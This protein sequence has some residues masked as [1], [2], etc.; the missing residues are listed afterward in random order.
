MSDLASRVR[1]FFPPS[2]SFAYVS[3]VTQKQYDTAKSMILDLL[4]IGVP[5]DHLLHCG[6]SRELIYFTFT[7]L[8]LR[9]PVGFDTAGIPQYSPEFLESLFESHKPVEQPDAVSSVSRIQEQPVKRVDK[10]ADAPSGSTSATPA[11]PTSGS[12]SLL[13]IEQQRRRE[14]LARK[15]V[16]ASRK[17]KQLQ[18]PALRT[19]SPQST[20]GSSVN[21]PFK[22]VE[23]TPAE[24]AP[25]ATVDDFLNSIGPNQ[26][27][28]IHEPLESSLPVPDGMDVDE[29]PGLGGIWP[30]EELT[31]SIV[32]PP[33]APT[34]TSTPLTS[35]LP[36]STP[37]SV[38]TPAGP[39]SS[40]ES[41]PL[42]PETSIAPHR[43]GA[44]RP[45]AADF[46]DAER[47]HTNSY[48]HSFSNGQSQSYP[49]YGNRRTGGFAGI[50]STRRCVIDLSDSEDEDYSEEMDAP[51]Q[52]RSL[53][54]S[55]H[56][57]F[58]SHFTV[59]GQFSATN[60]PPQA[61]GNSLSSATLLEKELEIKRMREMIAQKEQTRLRK[62]VG[63]FTWCTFTMLTGRYQIT[64]RNTPGQSPTPSVPNAATPEPAPSTPILQEEDIPPQPSDDIVM[65]GTTATETR[66]LHPFVCLH[67][68]NSINSSHHS[69]GYGRCT[70]CDRLPYR[71][72]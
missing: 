45:V 50:T 43:R 46:V 58:N 60:T 57:S 55:R 16:I 13:D 6:L 71:D 70:D 47:S 27:T 35:I 72:E 10:L 56:G 38:G 26:P 11:I 22:D 18:T 25:A 32:E 20:N 33:P 36:V 3:P 29:I 42:L 48:H 2:A 15:A 66:K 31:A 28:D 51:P 34:P 63:L 68:I 54:P 9:L 44:K 59:N 62:L 67:R 8:R 61:G 4:G 49:S 17:G 24:I 39:P 21:T 65:D 5:S 14:L 41:T 1:Q 23:M 52:F 12:P 19:P 53:P 40:G 7:E 64:A 30:S 37:D 69:G